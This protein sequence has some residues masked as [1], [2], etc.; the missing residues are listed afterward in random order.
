M[1]RGNLSP[2]QIPWCPSH[3]K[4]NGMTAANILCRPKTRCVFKYRLF[5]SRFAI[6]ADCYSDWA[7]CNRKRYKKLMHSH[8]M[9]GNHV[10]SHA[11]RCITNGFCGALPVIY[12]GVL[13]GRWV[14]H[15][16]RCVVDGHDNGANRGSSH[17]LRKYVRLPRHLWWKSHIALKWAFSSNGPFSTH[18]SQFVQISISLTER[19]SC[20]L[21]GYT[22]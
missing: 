2:R 5:I 21:H 1:R 9:V 7:T 16:S 14:F 3:Y 4:S 13:I 12:M 10:K 6:S 22:P 11:C 20:I 15:T 17:S 8:Q 19:F 18:C